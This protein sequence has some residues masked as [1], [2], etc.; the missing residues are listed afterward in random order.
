MEYLKDS[1]Q[2]PFCA[3]FIDRSILAE[4]KLAFAIFDKFPVNAGHALIIPK[5]H[6]ANYFG[7]SPD[8]KAACWQLLDEVKRLLDA[9][10]QPQGYNIGVNVGETAGQTVMHVHLHLIPRYD[11]D[12]ENP[13]GGVRGVIPGKQQY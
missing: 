8:E 1:I 3:P 11:G 13:R 12:V 6:V 4:N 9:D 7:L 2:C 5:R 10:F